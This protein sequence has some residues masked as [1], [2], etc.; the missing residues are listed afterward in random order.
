[1]GVFKDALR[2]R[3]CKYS[4]VKYGMTVA[5]WE[6]FTSSFGTLDKD[7]TNLKEIGDWI[8]DYRLKVLD[9]LKQ[10]PLG[11]VSQ[12]DLIK[13]VIG[14]AN[15]N[16]ISIRDMVREQLAQSKCISAVQFDSMELPLFQGI[17]HANPEVIVSSI[18]EA[19]PYALMYCKQRCSDSTTLDDFD[20]FTA[21]KILCN[22]GSAMRYANQIWV[23]ALW[24]DLY[25]E[26]TDSLTFKFS[27]KS[28]QKNLVASVCRKRESYFAASYVAG[29]MKEFSLKQLER[30]TPHECRIDRT[31][32]RNKIAK[33]KFK[34]DNARHYFALFATSDESLDFLLDQ[35]LPKLSDVTTRQLLFGMYSL[36]SLISSEVER[37]KDSDV[38]SLNEMWPYVQPISKKLL[39]QALHYITTDDAIK[40]SILST[41]TYKI[42]SYVEEMMAK[43][44]VIHKDK[45]YPVFTS[46]APDF[47]FLLEY[48]LT[49]GGIDLD[50]RGAAFEKAVNARIKSI[51]DKN[52]L[53]EY[54]FGS[55]KV[56]DKNGS[57]FEEIDACFRL[58]STLYVVEAKAFKH[59]V[60]PM[61][62]AT[63]FNEKLTSAAAQAQRK[64]DFITKN[65]EEVSELKNVKSITKVLPIV[66][67]NT[68]LGVMHNPLSIPIIDLRILA[69]YFEKGGVE[70]VI[71]TSRPDG[72]SASSFDR[73]YQNDEEC[74]ANF[75]EYLAEPP[76]MKRVLQNVTSNVQ[77]LICV[78]D[79][80]IDAY[81]ETYQANSN[82]HESQVNHHDKVIDMIGAIN[83]KIC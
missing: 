49:I 63:F 68:R 62:N 22:L 24:E 19:M 11:D 50:V 13:V 46:S 5:K 8:L 51:F 9:I 1:M 4:P 56:F 21:A 42:D 10:V 81:Y 47:N 26:K 83:S 69:C 77:R 53:G 79:N 27:E 80:A 20:V 59:P 18:S 67:L 70:T 76:Q 57:L 35:P 78:E 32:R 34:L 43:L 29:D 39:Y 72:I 3:G 23:E 45:Y 28:P 15:K 14:A 2:K 75:Y 64:A 52:K 73:F 71:T 61:S 55:K 6:N 17:N 16:Y 38:M 25:L 33:K 48:W 36:S 66:V 82:Y 58:G 37:V 30:K 41:L 12:D 60:D 74:C 7:D 44:F 65:L 54:V 40:E 31:G